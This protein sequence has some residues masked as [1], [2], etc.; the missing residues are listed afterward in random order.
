MPLLVW[1][2]HFSNRAAT[3]PFDP[4]SSLSWQMFWP[5]PCLPPPKHFVTIHVLNLQKDPLLFPA[6]DGSHEDLGTVPALGSPQG[7]SSAVPPFP[8][9]TGHIFYL[10]SMCSY[11]LVGKSTLT[12]PTPC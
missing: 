5:K 10:H 3:I 6:Q 11:Q 8:G 12:A 2:S 7:L 1:I 9:H 4:R